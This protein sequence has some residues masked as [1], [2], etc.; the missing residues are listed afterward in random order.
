[1][2]VIVSDTTPLNYL[3]LIEAVDI[4]PRLYTRVLIPPAVR[5]E[6]NQPNTPELVRSWLAQ[7]PSWLE[8]VSPSLP[9]DP[10]LSPPGCRRDTGHCSRFR[11]P[12]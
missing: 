3:V 10:A 9:P 1:M 4:L 8:V 6:L 2:P 7:S 5:E 11:I 12:G